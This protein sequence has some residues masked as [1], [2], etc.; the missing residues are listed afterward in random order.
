MAISGDKVSLQ[1][2]FLDLYDGIASRLSIPQELQGVLGM[3]S[4]RGLNQLL[5]TQS[6]LLLHLRRRGAGVRLAPSEEELES[7]GG[8]GLTGRVVEHLRT[9]LNGEGEDASR[10]TV[11]LQILY[12]QTS[13]TEG[14]G[15][16]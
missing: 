13:L 10:A 2:L 8:A 1:L 3:E 16:P 6:E 12:E 15:S 7:L 11:A 14:G 5:D 9:M 4:F